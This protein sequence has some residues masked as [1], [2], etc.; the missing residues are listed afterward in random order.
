MTTKK[1]KKAPAQERC[2]L[3]LRVDPKVKAAVEALAKRAGL[4][5]TDVV[6]QALRTAVG[7]WKERIIIALAPKATVV[8]K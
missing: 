4:T 6:E 5:T 2:Q 8:A 3:N 7:E 1:T